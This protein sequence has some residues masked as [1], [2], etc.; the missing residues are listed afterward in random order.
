MPDVV[1]VG[2]GITG[3]AAAYE[4]ARAGHSVLVLEKRRLAA[5]ASGRTLGGVRQSG[6]HLAELPLA[7]AAVER[8]AGLDSELGA[9]TGYRRHGNLRLAR[10]P[11]EVESIKALVQEQCSRGLE[12]DYL[13]DNASIRAVAPA[14]GPQM[15]AASFCPSDGHA[16]P[17]PS[18]TA[19]ASAARRHGADVREGV[20]V[21]SIRTKGGHV[22]GVETD[23]GVVGADRVVVASG[24]HA[25]E[26]LRPLG[27]DLPLSIKLVCVLQ[28]VPTEPVFA[29]VFGVANADAAGR[30]EID[31]RFR[32]TT[33]IGPWAHDPATGDE[34]SIQPTVDDIARLI[35]VSVSVLPVLGQ[36]RV[37]RVWG[38]LIDLTPDALPV[39]DGRTGVD[40]LGVAAGFSGHGFGIAPITGAILANIALG[41]PAEFDLAPFRLGRFRLSTGR[42]AELTLHG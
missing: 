14:I 18:V 42:E 29:Q 38:G 8:W 7:L 33:G 26:L 16:D 4:I 9:P 3:A 24:I 22:Y 36:T 19:F 1:I 25:P 20:T 12:I 2:G 6:R 31:G 21:R 40:G 10:T 37:A 32:I 11:G 35:R 27:L 39:I 13:P 15:L 34:A 17:I 5:M 30:Q 28:S 41:R 23:E